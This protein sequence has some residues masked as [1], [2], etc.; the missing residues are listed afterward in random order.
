M[1]RFLIRVGGSFCFL[2]SFALQGQGTVQLVPAKPAGRIVSGMPVGVGQS[3]SPQTQARMSA[4]ASPTGG[5]PP[6]NSAPKLPNEDDLRLQ[7]FLK[8]TFDRRASVI[9]KELTKGIEPSSATDSKTSESTPVIDQAPAKS[10]PSN[11]A[12]KVARQAA[13]LKKRLDE[14]L[15]EFQLDVTLGH[16]EAVRGFYA[17]IKTNHLQQTYQHL[18][19]SL[20]R[21]A[22]LRPN[23]PLTTQ[24]GT[25]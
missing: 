1:K 22:G 12:Q 6:S 8:L 19:Q 4:S 21:P 24:S 7:K 20:T 15:K 11:D 5:A 2:M 16:W 14:E 3:I 17:S 23:Q 10:E 18:L 9:L 25:A 13:E